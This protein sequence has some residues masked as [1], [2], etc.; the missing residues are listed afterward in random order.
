MGQG[1]PQEPSSSSHYEGRLSSAW[2]SAM[3][4][5]HLPTERLQ[6]Y[7][8]SLNCQVVAVPGHIAAK[9]TRPGL[10]LEGKPKAHFAIDPP[11]PVNS[12]VEVFPRSLAQCLCRS[13]EPGF[14]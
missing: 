7:L 12:L 6:L 8:F 4:N 14:Y 3:F 9:E 5:S 1:G 2:S 13:L 10:W 11:R